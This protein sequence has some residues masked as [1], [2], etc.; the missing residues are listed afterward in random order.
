MAKR[1]IL[2]LMFL[3]IAL[4]A[5]CTE[6]L[7]V[8]LFYSPHCKF[9]LRFKEETLPQLKAKYKDTVAWRELDTANDQNNL[10][11]LIATSRQ[12]KRKTANVPSVL[13]GE[14]F[15]V[16]DELKTKL[17]ATIALSLKQKKNP[18][19]AFK[20]NLVEVFKELSLLTVIGGGLADGINPCAFAVIV[21][22]VSF[23]AVH[24]YRKRD[25]VCI[26]SFY[27]LAVFTTYLLIGLGIFNFLYRLSGFYLAIK[28]F[29]YL[30][31]AFCF[32]LAGLSLYDRFRFKETRSSG[33]MI[34]QLPKFLKKKINIVIGKGL[35]EK[36]ERTVVDLAFT[37]FVVGV[38]VSLLEAACTGQVYVPT[39]VFIL[40]YAPYR[41]RALGYLVLYNLMFVLP[42]V[43][44]FIL[45]LAGVSSQK[46]TDFLKR[47]LAALK[48]LL[49]IVFFSLG[50]LL[51]WDE[52]KFSLQFY[53][54]AFRNFC[55]QVVSIKIR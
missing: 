50:I 19:Y 54:D 40:Q 27:C 44:I 3:C 24:G 53:F 28:F 29:Y 52:V 51:I 20:K 46:F 35:R 41:L 38:G 48:I 42:L 22:F 17:D 8:T 49:A 45:A 23:L 31:A 13:V 10:A 21:F 55:Q 7:T 2:F 4:P 37:S 32:I 34:L 14:Y 36:K 6:K 18:I 16:G 30:V 47:H 11:L 39:I 26:G 25:I 33:E 15:L 43:I 12:F 1:V 5:Y 9:C